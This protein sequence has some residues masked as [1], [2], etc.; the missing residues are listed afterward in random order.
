MQLEVLNAET[1]I[2]ELEREVKSLQFIIKHTLVSS[3]SRRYVSISHITNSM[4]MYNKAELEDFEDDTADWWKPMY[5][6]LEENFLTL[7]DD[8][9]FKVKNIV[10]RLEYFIE[11]IERKVKNMEEQALRDKVREGRKVDDNVEGWCK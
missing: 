9:D 6:K 11:C 2:E 7:R 4:K 1:E 5:G 8:G 3:S 10:E